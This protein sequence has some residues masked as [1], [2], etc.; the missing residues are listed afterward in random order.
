MTELL[1]ARR[2]DADSGLRLLRD[3]FPLLRLAYANG[4]HGSILQERVLRYFEMNDIKP[5]RYLVV[6]DSL[7]HHEILIP[8][9]SRTNYYL[10]DIAESVV[11]FYL[12]R[13]LGTSGDVLVSYVGQLEHYIEKIEEVRFDDRVEEFIA[14]ARMVINRV[15]SFVRAN[16]DRALLE[17]EEARSDQH[18]SQYRLNRLTDFLGRYIAPIAR[19]F[20]INGEV[21][22]NIERLQLLL[23]TLER[24]TAR[25]LDVQIRDMTR[26]WQ[27]DQIRC[28]KALRD[29]A[30]NIRRVLSQTYNVILS[31]ETKIE[32]QDRDR[33]DAHFDGLL[34]LCNVENE[35]SL[36]DDFIE[37]TF[38]D[39]FE[40]SAV[41]DDGFRL[42]EPVTKEPKPP[43]PKWIDYEDELIKEGSTPDLLAWI[44]ENAGM[45]GCGS[46]DLL[47]SATHEFSHRGELSKVIFTD[48]VAQIDFD[49]VVISYKKIKVSYA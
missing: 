18:A 47:L 32:K 22:R 13:A 42:Y 12:G 29:A 45:D 49:D 33:F 24:S 15:N 40:L 43:A 8:N 38:V 23:R 7:A 25:D 1:Q 19:I 35:F 14:D 46:F 20:E 21:N 6:L 30:H 41:F 4:Q 10:G 9:E 11:S 34:S 16:R 5:D 26:Q 17:V 27:D 39:F 37:R 3:H 48:E 44:V 28:S 36:T 2:L 31:A